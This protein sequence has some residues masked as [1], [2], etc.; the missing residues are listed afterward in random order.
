MEVVSVEVLLEVKC[1]VVFPDLLVEPVG[2]YVIPR[3]NF[4]VIL[5]YVVFFFAFITEHLG[6]I[7]DLFFVNQHFNWLLDSAFVD[8]H[9]S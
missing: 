9:I 2:L 4:S 5:Q 1:P 6:L 3:P 8:K 7:L